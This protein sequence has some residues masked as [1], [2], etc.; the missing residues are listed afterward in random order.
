MI[1]KA[2][3]A[4]ASGTMKIVW[5]GLLALLPAV[6]VA[7]AASLEQ[8]YLAAR[9]THIRKLAVFDKPGAEA[10]RSLKMQEA[11]VADLE[12]QMKR[13]VG[14]PAPAV[15]GIA[16]TPKLNNDTLLKGDQ[17]FG[18]LD[19]LVYSSEDYKTR[20][21]VTTEGLF[22]T[23]LREHRK[24]WK[25]NN[26][27][28]DPAKALAHVSFYT[29][30]VNADAALSKYA[31]LP[32]KKP[33]AATLA[34]A[35]LGEWAQDDGPWEPDELVISVMQGGKLYV[36][37]VPASTKVGPFA[38]CQAV[39]DE[40]ERKSNEAFQRAPHKSNAKGPDGSKIREDG[41]VAFRRCFAERAP[42]DNGFADLV[43]QAQV[44]A[45]ALPVK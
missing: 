10:D 34:F 29:Q 26:V 20:V 15:P 37:R 22:K 17:G 43:R 42:Q 16:P 45:D 7:G 35:M 4:I 6:V 25:D 28:E 13:I 40:A 14:T 21:V 32:I 39:W 23:W 36:V 18:M 8:S 38:P 5:A 41:A 11:A 9:D 12:Q 33:A 31:V 2:R 44:I 24:W 19:G 3:Q 1:Y 27:L 30:A